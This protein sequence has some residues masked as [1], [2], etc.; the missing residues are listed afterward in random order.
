MNTIQ[1]FESGFLTELYG[2]ETNTRQCDEAFRSGNYDLAM[3]C[4][5]AALREVKDMIERLEKA[6]R[7]FYQ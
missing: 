1:R 3:D 5:E 6:Q 4:L 2:L 7:G